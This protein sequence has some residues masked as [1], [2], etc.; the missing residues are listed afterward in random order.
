MMSDELLTVAEMARADALTI[1]AGTPGIAL[2]EAAG[3]AVARIAAAT[4]PRARIAVLCGPGNN[5][6]D[7]FVAA[8]LLAR[9]GWPVRV[10]LLGE[11]DRLK[12]DAALAAAR[13]TGPVVPLGPE[14]LDGCG[15]VID[16][17]FGAGLSRP[18]DGAAAATLT[19]VAR[20][21]LPVVAVDVP[22]GVAGDS[23][24]VLGPAPDC[25]ATVTFFR[26]KPGHCLLPG[27]IKC[28]A[29]TV[30]A[31]GIP[32][33]VLDQI[34]PLAAENHAPALPAPALDGHKFRRGHL[35]VVGGPMAGAGRLAALAGRR[36]GAGLVTLAVPADTLP[37]LRGA[38]PGTIL[39]RR[40][41]LAALLADPRRNA[42]LIGPGAGSDAATRADL[43]TVL[44]AGRPAVLDA[45]ALT[46]WRDDP[47]AL[48]AAL[49]PA[50]VLTPHDGEFAALFGAVAGSRLDRARAAAARSGAVVLLKG[51]DTVIAAPDGRARI[52]TD[53]P[54]DLATAGSGDVLAG[55]IG[56][57][58]A[59]GW[60]AFAAAAAGAA[61]HG[62]AGRIAGRGLIAEDL[63]TAMQKP[64]F[65]A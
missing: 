32:A 50:Q 13:W 7:G 48:F 6:G 46:C 63:L 43:R 28:G 23:G 12:G 24:A 34:R 59:Q 21:G 64:S 3:W 47:A 15:G 4:L 11:R 5:G 61:L 8:R 10:A 60:D 26:K 16:A 19:E 22:S 51:P 45:D 30:A 54:P 41:Q 53:A 27:R 1:A 17:V 2:M 42:V 18:L 65:F 9:R 39:A 20:R 14:A 58:L 52:N 57:L 55:L 37:A 49:S 38:E 62:R 33:T 31:I 29:I 25:V 35:L 44:A 56:G 36:I 40:D